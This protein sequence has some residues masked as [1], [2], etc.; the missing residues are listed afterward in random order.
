MKV[1]TTTPYVVV[2][3]G[4][5]TAISGPARSTVSEAFAEITRLLDIYKTGITKQRI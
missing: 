3:V 2:T 5:T 4:Q 1:V